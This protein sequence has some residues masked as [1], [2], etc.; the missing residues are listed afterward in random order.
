MGADACVRRVANSKRSR[1]LARVALSTTTGTGRP[2]RRGVPVTQDDAPRRLGRVLGLRLGGLL[3]VRSRAASARSSRC[4][5]E[6]DPDMSHATCPSGWRRCV[7]RAPIGAR[8]R[9]HENNQP[10][11]SF[12]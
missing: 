11:G 7:A 4:T 2:R 6:G 5:R 8:E 3:G 1:I 9:W 10:T 12:R